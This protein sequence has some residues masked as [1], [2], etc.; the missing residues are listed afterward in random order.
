MA[1]QV[2]GG[3][4]GI[5]ADVNTDKELL[6]QARVVD[7]F[8]NPLLV[9]EDLHLAISPEA[10]L[11]YE[12][13]DGAVVN[14]LKWNPTFVTMTIAQ[15]TGFIT[16]NS[17]AITTIN[18]SANITSNRQLPLYGTKPLRVQINAKTNVGPQA[19]A[20]MELGLGFVATNAAPTD[21]AFFR[22]GSDATFKAVVNRGGT[23]TLSA[24][25]TAPPVADSTLF[26]IV[27]VEDLVLFYV[28][29]VLVATVATPVT[30]AYPVDFGHQPVFAR[31]YTGGSAPGTA[32]QMQIGQVVVVQESLNSN[33]LW[34][35]TLASLGQGSYQSPITA[36]AQTSNF[37]NSAAPSSATLSNTAAGYTTL[38]GKYQFAAVTGAETDY[39]LFAYQVP[40]GFQ[41]YVT[42]IAITVMNTV[43]AVATTP[44]TM[45]WG[46]AVNSSAATLASLDAAGPPMTWAPRRMHI[47]QQSFA[48]GAVVGAVATD[49][50]RGFDPPLIVDS[51]RFFH[52]ILRMPVATNTATEIFRGGVMITG[53]FE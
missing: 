2:Q 24:A 5:V 30:A 37:A 23:E 4:S 15:A 47:G 50:V 32:P 49:I 27:L 26:E 10:L 39:A 45:E 48:T 12:Q 18:T 33:K 46:V 1:L 31:T 22:W 9:T 13:I 53:Y 40:T 20:T 38:G 14:N 35:E 36:F 52:V 16:L 41:L 19:N 8:G 34:K 28:D 6:T 44:T 11:F 17:S 21:G 3:T 43:V 29:D 25:L 42:G 51:G 7:D